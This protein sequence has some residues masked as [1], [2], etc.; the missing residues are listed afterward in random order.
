MSVSKILGAGALVVG[1]VILSLDMPILWKIWLIFLLLL[2]AFLGAFSLFRSMVHVERHTLLVIKSRF[3]ERAAVGEQYVD[4]PLPFER[5]FVQMP[6]YRLDNDFTFK[7]VHVPPY[8]TL[9]RV[10][11]RIQYAIQPDQWQDVLGVPNWGRRH[12]A[13]AQ[14]LRVSADKAL[15]RPMFWEMLLEDVLYHEA[16]NV[17]AVSSL[18]HVPLSASQHRL[19]SQLQAYVAHELRKRAIRWGIVICAVTITALEKDD[20]DAAREAATREMLGQAAARSLRAAREVVADTDLVHLRRSLEAVRDFAEPTD[21]LLAHLLSD[22]LRETHAT[23][24]YL[25]QSETP[26]PPERVK[27]VGG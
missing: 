15:L 6:L 23:P 3:G 11:L 8:G 14:H 25:Q 24:L 17:L 13:Y 19:C 26:A 5:Q 16:A 12:A 1:L 4:S 20:M 21:Q 27:V 2:I 22:A 18:Q 7:E 10:A 9:H